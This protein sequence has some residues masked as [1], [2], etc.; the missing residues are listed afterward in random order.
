[1]LGSWFTGKG[2]A[3]QQEADPLIDDVQ[4]SPYSR[5]HPRP[6]YGSSDVEATEQLSG[7][8]Q[9]PRSAF[10]LVSTP[11]DA[12]L[13]EL[14]RIQ[15]EPSPDTVHAT[16]PKV[17]VADLTAAST[18]ENTAAASRPEPLSDPFSGELLGMVYHEPEGSM[19]SAEFESVK[20]D[21]WS[22]LGQIRRLQAEIANMHIQMEGVSGV[23]EGR[24]QTARTPAGLGRLS[25][26]RVS[27]SGTAGEWEEGDEDEEAE[28]KKAREAEFNQLADK[29][30][31][32]KKD[33][34]QVMAKVL[35]SNNVTVSSLIRTSQLN[36]LSEALSSFHA[37]RM[38]GASFNSTSRS[39]THNSNAAPSPP[40][41]AEQTFPR[42]DH[43]VHG[44]HTP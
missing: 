17:K 3:H 40:S 8:A 43:S 42:S 32:R 24:S 27:T 21:L 10:P 12:V 4:H 30:D 2:K 20:D 38:P 36:E 39:A 9:Q 5:I 28:R 11:H 22:Q 37:L 1:M 25:M 23:S 34:D 6:S 33:I 44:I 15:A 19:D 14:T 29:F 16:R 31:G 26:R 7:G 13:A 18:T 35:T 41:T